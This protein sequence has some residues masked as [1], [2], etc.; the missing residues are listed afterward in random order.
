M[1]A[2]LPKVRVAA[3][4]V[5]PVFLDTAKT[6]QKTVSLIREAASNRADLVVF[7]ETYIPAFP[8]WAAISAPI[9]NHSF[10]TRLAQESLLIDGKEMRTL[11]QACAQNHIYAHIGFNERSPH[12]TG[13]LW[14]SS[15]LISDSGQ[16][17]NHHRKLM[18]TFYEKLVW[19]PG[20]GAGLRVVDT[21]RLGK[22]GSLICGENT[23]PL[24]RWSLMAQG[25]Q[26]HISSWPPVWPT[27]RVTTAAGKDA[28]AGAAGK[29][30]DN[31]AANRTRSAAHCFEAKC[32]G[33]LCSGFMDKA[34]R[35]ELIKHAPEAAATLD[36]I[37]Q[38]ASLF[39]DP[40]GAQVG[41]EVVGE[42]GIAYGELDLNATIEGKQ[43]HDVVGTGYQRY[44]IFDLRVNRRRLGPEGVFGEERREEMP[45]ASPPPRFEEQK[46]EPRVTAPRAAST[47]GHGVG[48]LRII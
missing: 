25:E 13:C 24:A 15:V 7:P 35:N 48:G 42:E 19:S 29:Q 10:F 1:S 33:V 17:L 41:E 43:F 9:D 21:Q 28:A 37:T 14:N 16:I 8:L 23:N 47:T 26:L 39:L 2:W 5:A 40:T 44:D 3:C 18:P 31:L 36:G 12:S 38:G 4:N 34:M 22:I 45:A 30:Y 20:D 32:F 6:V 27:R 11:Q 46:E